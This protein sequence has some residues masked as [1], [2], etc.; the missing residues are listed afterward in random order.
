M[1]S[2]N[3][4]DDLHEADWAASI[5]PNSKDV[6]DAYQKALADG[7]T[8][9]IE[10]GDFWH[11]LAETYPAEPPKAE[12]ITTGWDQ[13]AVELNA[14]NGFSSQNA[15]AEPV[16]VIKS[17]VAQKTDAANAQSGESVTFL[18]EAINWDDVADEVNLE[19][20]YASPKLKQTF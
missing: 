12:S 14:A 2:D 6:K 4:H 15:K 20:G 7:R 1:N 18:G 3:N 5:D 16:E 13:I 10:S 19:A 11:W 8:P 17:S 9:V